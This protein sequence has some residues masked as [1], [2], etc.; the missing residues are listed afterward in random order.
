[1][2]DQDDNKLCAACD[3]MAKPQ[4]KS[5]ASSSATETEQ[6][7]DEDDH[8][9]PHR[10]VLWSATMIYSPDDS[11]TATATSTRTARTRADTATAITSPLETTT[12][13]TALSTSFED[14]V[15]I[16]SDDLH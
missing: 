11:P 10:P 4:G 7:Q 15:R 16:L 6:L 1:M 13:A 14:R 5:D 12:I 8:P 2:I 3:T 9:D